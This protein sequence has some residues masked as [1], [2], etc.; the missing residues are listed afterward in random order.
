[1]VQ[2]VNWLHYDSTNDSVHCFTCCKAVKDGKAVTDGVTEQAFLVKALL[3]GKMRLV[4]LMVLH[5]HKECTQ[6]LN[7]MNIAKEFVAG[8]EG[9]LQMFGDCWQ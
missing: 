7:L 6:S 9:G 8:R 3:I 1:M 5:V 4:N 2:Q